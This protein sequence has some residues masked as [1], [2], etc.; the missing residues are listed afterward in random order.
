MEK[1]QAK[2]TNKEEQVGGCGS[3]GEGGKRSHSYKEVR[4]WGEISLWA[5]KN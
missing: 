4:S 3:V 5:G 1:A 2:E